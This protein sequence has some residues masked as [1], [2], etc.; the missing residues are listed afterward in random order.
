LL[1]AGGAD[2]R[3]GDI[4]EPSAEVHGAVDFRRGAVLDPTLVKRMWTASGVA[5]GM[6]DIV[7]DFAEDLAAAFGPAAPHPVVTGAWRLGDAR[8]VV[9]SPVHA[10]ERLGYVA[11]VSFADGLAELAR[12]QMR[13]GVAQ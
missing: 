6:P 9:A 1:A 10:A 5:S 4:V 8:H 11:A 13:Q 12:A 2:V 7:G 3:A